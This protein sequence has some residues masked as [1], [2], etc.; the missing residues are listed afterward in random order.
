MSLSATEVHRLKSIGMEP[1]TGLYSPDSPIFRFSRASDS[2]PHADPRVADSWSSAVKSRFL[3]EEH[4]FIFDRQVPKP[5]KQFIKRRW[6]AIF[7]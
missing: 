6:L 1:R 5:T 7:F 4:S 2:L 3:T